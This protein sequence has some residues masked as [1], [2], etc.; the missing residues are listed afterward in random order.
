MT[1][2]DRPLTTEPS[3]RLRGTHGV[4]VAD[5]AALA[6]LPAKGLTLTLMAN[7]NR[8]GHRV[9]EDLHRP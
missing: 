3:G 2:D 7:A 9:L 1:S 4:F 5:G 6:Y 8:I